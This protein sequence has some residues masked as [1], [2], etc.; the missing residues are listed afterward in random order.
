MRTFQQIQD[1]A[2]RYFDIA[3]ESDNDADVEVV[4]A[5]VNTANQSR[6]S[7]DNWKFMLSNVYTLDV[8]SGTQDYIL[9]QTNVLRL[10]Y[11]KDSVDGLYAIQLPAEQ[12]AW[13]R[14]VPSDRVYFDINPDGSAVAAQ[15]T[16]ADTLVLTCTAADDA[17]LYI[18]GEDED[19]LSISETVDVDGTTTQ[20]FAKVTYYAKTGEFTGILTLAT[21]GGTTLLTLAA[22]EAG[23]SYAVVHFYQEPTR[24]TTFEYKYFRKP[25]VMTRDLDRPDIPFPHSA[26]LVYDALL[27]LATY[28]ELDSESV[29]IWRDKQDQLKNNLY[30]QKLEGNSVGAQ[31][32]SIRPGY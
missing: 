17:S 11:L 31:N 13:D 6:A 32:M 19:G 2:L 16:E 15:P 27:D 24:N 1:E 14:N 26:I 23:K 10:Q 18:E 3:N 9:P 7:E 8:V 20:E 21:T 30:L 29:N 12:D 5:A 28:N 25:R 4:K 22:D